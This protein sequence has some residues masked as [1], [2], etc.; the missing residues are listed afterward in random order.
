[1]HLSICLSVCPVCFP[2]SATYKIDMLRLAYN[3]RVA[4]G[5]HWGTAPPVAGGAPQMKI[6]LY[7]NT[8]RFKALKPRYTALMIII[9]MSVSRHHQL[10]PPALITPMS[11]AG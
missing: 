2:N 5:G 4:T 10:P 9:I 1:M 7:K 3:M 11:C 8:V 6:L